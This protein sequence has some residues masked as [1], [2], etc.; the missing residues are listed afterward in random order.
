MSR[1]LG[2]DVG[3]KRVGIAI[4]D[5]GTGVIS[6]LQ[7]LSRAQG[8]AEKAIIKLVQ[9]YGVEKLVAGLPL[10]ANGAI[11]PQ[12]ERVQSF[13]RRLGKR[14][15]AEIIFVDEF[16]TSKEAE[17]RLRASSKRAKVEKGMVDALS[18]T[19]ILQLYLDSKY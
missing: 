1:I 8:R 14:I 11:T 5:P 13:C 9:E 10:A 16:G 15:Q 3:D 4:C 19:I 6:S 7:T 17:E 12:A 2:L 18:A